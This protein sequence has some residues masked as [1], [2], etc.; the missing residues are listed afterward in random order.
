MATGA[1]L[2]YNTG[3]SAIAMANAIFGSG[4]SVVNASYS[5]DSRA[6]GTFDGGDA[7]AP[8]VTP[9]DSGVILSTGQVRAFTQS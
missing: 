3:A 6:S 7:L 8:G 4:V 5:G 1:E 9:S 2:S